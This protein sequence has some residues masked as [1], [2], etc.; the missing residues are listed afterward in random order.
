MEIKATETFVL[1]EE[2][3]KAWDTV[4]DILDTIRCRSEQVDANKDAEEILF[5]LGDFWDKYLEG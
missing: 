4:E 1:T 3:E 5:A 2:E